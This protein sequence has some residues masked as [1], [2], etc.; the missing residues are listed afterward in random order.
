MIE[1]KNLEIG[2][3]VWRGGDTGFCYNDIEIV[4]NISYKFDEIFMK[5]YKVIHLGNSMYDSRTGNAINPPYA[6][7][8]KPCKQNDYEQI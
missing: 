7:Y 6:Y 2:D 3:K 4:T 1:L 8:L 5:I